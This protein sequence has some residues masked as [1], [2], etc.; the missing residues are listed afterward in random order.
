MHPHYSGTHKPFEHPHPHSFPCLSVIEVPHVFGAPLKCHHHIL[1]ITTDSRTLLSSGNTCPVLG[2][3]Q[4][5]GTI[6]APL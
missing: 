2:N 5:Q 3:P 4:F 1:G 6:T